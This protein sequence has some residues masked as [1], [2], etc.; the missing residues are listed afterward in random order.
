MRSRF[1]WL[2]AILFMVGEKAMAAEIP[3]I[4][5]A[6]DLKFAIEEVAVSFTAKSGVKLRLSFGS[7]GNFARQIEQG[8]PFELF[9]SADDSYIRRLAEKGF[10]RGEGISYAVGRLAIVVPKKSPISLDEKL[11]GLRGAKINRLAIA[12]PEHAPYGRAAEEILRNLGLW[13]KLKDHLVL[14]ENV[15]QAAQ[16]AAG[17]STDGGIIAYSLVKAPGMAEKTRYQLISAELHKPLDQRMVLMKNAGM[18]AQ[19]FF[20]Y[21]QSPAAREILASY[22]FR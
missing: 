17:G 2:L 14:G 4:A 16:F 9:L 13:E 21:L 15:S 3:A 18:N 5:A 20:D 19:L 1:F 10:T 11:D 7:S 12:N 6:S 8:A 22:G